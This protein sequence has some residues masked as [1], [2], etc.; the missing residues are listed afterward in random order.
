MGGKWVLK[1]N[2]KECRPVVSVL[3]SVFFLVLEQLTM[4]ALWR[5]R[6]KRRSTED[7]EFC[8]GG[9]RYYYHI[10]HNPV[11]LNVQWGQVRLSPCRSTSTYKNG[12]EIPTSFLVFCFLDDQL[13]VSIGFLAIKFIR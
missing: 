9:S 4:A 8:T 6:E 12:Y 11:P 13:Q 5:E 7:Q 3:F 10:N 1:A 2:K